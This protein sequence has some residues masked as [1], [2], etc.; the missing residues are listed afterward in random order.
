[1][2]VWQQAGMIGRFITK[3]L[4]ILPDNC[5]E[6]RSCSNQSGL[7]PHGETLDCHYRGVDKDC[8]LTLIAFRWQ[9]HPLNNSQIVNDVESMPGW[10][11]TKQDLLISLEG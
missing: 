10:F 3:G 2:P 5:N 8:I 6:D 11:H 7:D 9:K 1:M 4:S